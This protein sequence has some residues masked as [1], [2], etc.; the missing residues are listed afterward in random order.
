MPKNS[1]EHANARRASALLD[2]YRFGVHEAAQVGL[3]IGSLLDVEDGAVGSGRVQLQSKKPVNSRKPSL[4]IRILKLANIACFGELSVG[5][6]ASLLWI[7]PN[8]LEPAGK[9]YH[10]VKPSFC[11][12]TTER[13]GMEQRLD[14]GAMGLFSPVR[15][16]E[17]SLKVILLKDA[18]T[19]LFTTKAP[20]PNSVL[21]VMTL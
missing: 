4:S 1:Q 12:S 11:D 7:P 2:A 10:R 20:F 16:T 14:S 13:L 18:V 17:N 6:D 9:S 19:L 15:L 5:D 21:P 3:E 8:D